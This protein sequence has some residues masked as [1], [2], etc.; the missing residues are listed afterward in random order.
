M[1]SGTLMRMIMIHKLGGRRLGLTLA[2]AI[3]ACGGVVAA[4]Y[5]YFTPKP[6]LL[7]LSDGTEVFYLSN[8]VI[9]P[10]ADYPHPREIKIDGE[11]F[12][13]AA[14]ASQP[15]V[16]RSRLLVLTVIGE[17]ALRVIAHSNETGEEA[18]VLSGHV[19]ARK[20]YRSP[21]NEADT[22]LDGQEVMV[23]QTIDLQ[24]KET[25]DVP[26]LRTWSEALMASVARTQRPD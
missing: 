21:Q 22:L 2:V 5:A 17:T 14:A 23:N 13:R 20:A 6:R 19:E 24:E 12:I 3:V 16:V 11:A 9:Q 4:L 18:D 15:L 1:S 8:T 25:A 10:A 26:S 7:R